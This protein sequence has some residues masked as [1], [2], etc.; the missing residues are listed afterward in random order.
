[1]MVSLRVECVSKSFPQKCIYSE[2]SRSFGLGLHVLRGENGVGKTVLIEMLA[3]VLAPDA[4]VINLSGIGPS[5][6]LAYKSSLAYVPGKPSFFPSATGLEFLEFVASTKK[7][8]LSDCADLKKMIHGFKLDTY[9]SVP[10]KDMSLGTQKKL[11]LL[12]IAIGANQL[13]VMDEPTNGLDADSRLFFSLY[14]SSIADSKIV[15][16][17]THDALFLNDMNYQTLELS[18]AEKLL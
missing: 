4:G 6:S 10:F 15:I 16:M 17:A 12:T 8:R 7:I 18:N 11:F 3:G 13:I 5:Q 9:L 14:L 2:W 1:M